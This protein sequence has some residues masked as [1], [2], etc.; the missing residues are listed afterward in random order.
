M[1]LGVLG[2]LRWSSGTRDG[3]R[4][5]WKPGDEGGTK[6]VNSRGISVAQLVKSRTLDFSSGHELTGS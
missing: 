3:S 1:W 5:T 4:G 2:P 6:S